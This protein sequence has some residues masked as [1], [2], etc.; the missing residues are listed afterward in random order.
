MIMKKQIL[1]FT[2]GLALLGAAFT[3]PAQDLFSTLTSPIYGSGGPENGNNWYQ[4]FTTGSQ[5]ENIG[6][7]SVDLCYYAD[8]DFQ[9]A[10]YTAGD[11]QP[12]SLVSNGL[13]TGPATPVA[14]AFSGTPVLNT[15]TASGL[16]LAANTTYWL[17]FIDFSSSGTL[18]SVT[19]DPI[20][21]GSGGFTLGDSYQNFGSTYY[22]NN[23]AYDEPITP[24]FSINGV[25]PVPE[26][27]TLA[28]AGLGGLS[29][30]LLRRRK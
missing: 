1:G 18:F 25:E 15:Y 28:L 8:T 5:S 24:L 10:F 11:A 6:S 4:V 12:G 17:A 14:G 13:L 27:S 3:A 23:I 9:V 21:S 7:V 26:P 2:L 19:G 16:T 30:L 22:D 29:L 20:T